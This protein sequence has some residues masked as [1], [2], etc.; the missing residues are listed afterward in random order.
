[1][2][3]KENKSLIVLIIGIIAI[4]I[5]PYIL[6][7]ES[8]IV[9]F[10]ES[11]SYVGSTIGGCTAPIVGLVS[12]Y[13]LYDTL[14]QQIK[15]NKEQK[16]IAYDDQFK[17]T[18]FSLL[19]VQRDIT[20]HI[21]GQFEY[22]TKNTMNECS[23]T[24]KEGYRIILGIDF[25]KFAKNQLEMLRMAL[26]S[27][28]YN[29][30]YD[31]DSFQAILA[32]VSEQLIYGTHLPP[33]IEEEN[34]EM[35]RSVIQPHYIAYINKRFN[36]T[37]EIYD[38]YKQSSVENKIH[39]IYALFYAKYNQ[40]GYYFRH[41]YRILDFID[42]SEKDELKSNL[43]GLSRTQTKEK[44][45]NY[46]Q[47]IQSQMSREEMSILFYDAFVFPKMKDLLIKYNILSNLAVQDLIDEQH[48]CVRE[49]KLKDMNEY[50]MNL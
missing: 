47:F 37:K 41:L 26:G 33:E 31:P 17:T 3:L 15:F 16:R 34:N 8:G 46:A 1:M 24:S 30:N 7:L 42:S 32:S 36:I 21:S 44:Y 25:F 13:L 48:N 14:V 4:L 38:S 28:E 43:L 40:V 9:M 6:S 39:F 20:E 22:L 5:A 23:Y 29:V 2:K 27:S 11:S 12:I 10:G 19:Q 49:F 50:L 45:W 18:F 35:L